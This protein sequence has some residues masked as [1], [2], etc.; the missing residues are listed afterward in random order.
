MIGKHLIKLMQYKQYGNSWEEGQLNLQ[1]LEYIV[2][3]YVS[4]PSQC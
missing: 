3:G 2:K 4:G 1:C